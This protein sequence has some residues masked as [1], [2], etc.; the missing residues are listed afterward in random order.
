MAVKSKQDIFRFQIAMNNTL[1]KLQHH[2][3]GEP[4]NGEIQWPKS[5][6]P[7]KIELPTMRECGT[8][9]VTRLFR[10]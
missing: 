10:E 2:E 1:P 4:M 3:S 9:N 8:Q 6:Q 5:F 7:S